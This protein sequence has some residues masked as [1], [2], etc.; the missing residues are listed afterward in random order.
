MTTG[1]M[2]ML[3]VP[4]GWNQAIV[5]AAHPDDIPHGIA[6][7]VAAMFALNVPERTT[8]GTSRTTAVSAEVP[9]EEPQRAVG[10][11]RRQRLLG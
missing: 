10:L 8:I 1:G 11:E 7:A 3:V 9:G 6:A 4:E 5:V 2:P